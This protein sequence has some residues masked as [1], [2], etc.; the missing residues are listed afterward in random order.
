MTLVSS[1][2]RTGRTPGRKRRVKKSS[3]DWKPQWG[4]EGSQIYVSTKPG[5]ACIAG[6]LNQPPSFVVRTARESAE[7]RN[8][9]HTSNI[10]LNFA[11]TLGSQNI[12]KP[13]GVPMGHSRTA[14]IGKPTRSPASQEG[15]S[16]INLLNNSSM[17]R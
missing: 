7:M 14:I 13:A 16:W 5:I 4:K 3:H 15:A 6:G 12:W 9:D 8:C 11:L 10:S 1:G 17:R 2:K